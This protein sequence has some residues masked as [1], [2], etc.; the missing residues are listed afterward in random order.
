MTIS[1][2]DI[3]D[4]L[5]LTFKDPTDEFQVIDQSSGCGE[6]YKV[7]IVS[8]TFEGKKTFARHKY[9]NAALKEE[10]AKMHAFSQI[11]LTHKEYEERKERDLI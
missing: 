7:I 5:S 6:S 11:S 1:E 2:D 3:R 4:A 10:I 9:V 8:N